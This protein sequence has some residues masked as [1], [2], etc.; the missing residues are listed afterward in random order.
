MEYGTASAAQGDL[1]YVPSLIWCFGE[2][3]RTRFLWRKLSKTAVFIENRLTL[4]IGRFTCSGPVFRWCLKPGN[5]ACLWYCSG[6]VFRW[7]WKPGNTT[8]FLS[9]GSSY[10]TVMVRLFGLTRALHRSTSAM[11][12]VGQTRSIPGGMHRSLGIYW[13]TSCQKSKSLVLR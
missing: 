3:G 7:C 2:M 4:F 5:M 1:A 11:V 6:P 8:H 9:E 13:S 10:S 12:K